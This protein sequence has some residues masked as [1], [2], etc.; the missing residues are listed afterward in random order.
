MKTMKV[1]EKK[2]IGIVSDVCNVSEGRIIRRKGARRSANLVVA[3]QVLVNMLWRNFNYTNFMVRDILKYKNHASI[4]HCR[5]MHDQDHE[6]NPEYR[7]YYNKVAEK[8]GVYVND[9]DQEAMKNTNLSRKLETQEKDIV[10]YKDLWLLEKS[11]REK[12]Q[13]ELITFKKKYIPNQYN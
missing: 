2:I 13:Q 3:R 6:F 10:K 1:L 12:Y 5:K 8:L 9:E 11:Q 4:V 7:R